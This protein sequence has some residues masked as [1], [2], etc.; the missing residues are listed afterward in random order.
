[1]SKELKPCPFCGGAVIKDPSGLWAV[2][3]HKD[4]CFMKDNHILN[5]YFN[6]WNTRTTQWKPI[7]TAPKDKRILVWTGVEI[8]AA[9]WVKSP[10]TGDEAF[11]V[12]LLDDEGNQ[13]LVRPTHWAELDAPDMP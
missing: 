6:K 11:L 9:H 5:E 13:A 12:C 10:I 7:E 3:H 1:M 8:Y 2:I 4:G